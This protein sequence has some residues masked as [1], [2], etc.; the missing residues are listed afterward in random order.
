MHNYMT[1]R[2]ISASLAAFVFGVVLQS[3]LAWADTPSTL[4][5]IAD[6]ADR[7]CGIVS[8]E[9]SVKSTK[10]QGEINAELNGLLH[11]LANVGG[12]AAADFDSA[13]YQGLLQQDLPTT[14]QGV[15]ECKMHVFDLLRSS[16]L[17][18][19]ASIQPA[20]PSAP[21][22]D[23]LQAPSNAP[24]ID[25]VMGPGK[26]IEYGLYGCNNE[27]NKIACYVIVSKMTPGS[28][29]ITIP[30][31][32]AERIKLIDNFHIEHELRK[33]YFIDGLGGHQQGVN[34]GSGESVWLALEFSTIA[35]PI[36]SGRIILNNVAGAPQLRAVV[37]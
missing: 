22:S 30:T 34:F 26:S 27:L 24:T 28:A 7:I 19:S 12:S 35:R 13:H 11:R 29:E 25:T 31:F 18:G 20:V 14:L 16:I 5:A 36:S 37:N 21:S 2:I 3:P 8:T 15:R 32:R 1:W 33:A 6:T 17:P 10:A 4:T 9:G 23:L